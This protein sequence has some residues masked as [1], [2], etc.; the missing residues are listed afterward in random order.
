MINEAERPDYSQGAIFN[1]E[2]HLRRVH[3]QRSSPERPHERPKRS[4]T[5]AR[6]ARP[7][8]RPERPQ[9]PKGSHRPER[10]EPVYEVAE[11]MQ[12]RQRNRQPIFLVRWEN[13]PSEPDWTWE[14]LAHIKHTEAF[15]AW[16]KRRH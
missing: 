11:I 13:Y 3:V 6:P 9:R 5:P 15:A 12:Q 14:P 2:A 7:P 4:A 10:P 8:Q 16:K 1:Q